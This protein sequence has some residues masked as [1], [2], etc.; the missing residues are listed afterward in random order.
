MVCVCLSFCLCI[1]LLDVGEMAWLC[2]IEWECMHAESLS[3]CLCVCVRGTIILLD[4]AAWAAARSS[5]S[6]SSPSAGARWQSGCRKRR[7]Q[8]PT[9]SS[10]SASWGSSSSRQRPGT[11]SSRR[12][13]SILQGHNTVDRNA[14]ENNG[15]RSNVT[16]LVEHSSSVDFLFVLTFPAL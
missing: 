8:P 12:L 9:A 14:I 4:S 15:K 2:G 6:S 1:R 5:Q 13:L 16:N 7:L 11:N 3:M 10:F